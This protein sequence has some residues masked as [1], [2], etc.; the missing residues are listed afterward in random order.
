M[1]LK[2]QIIPDY[3]EDIG[4][5]VVGKETKVINKESYMFKR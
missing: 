3:M 4:D 2:K 5:K 1:S